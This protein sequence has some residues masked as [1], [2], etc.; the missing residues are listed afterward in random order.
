MEPAAEPAPDD[1]RRPWP[2]PAGP[3]TL[4]M[5]WHE[6]VFLHWPVPAEALRPLVPRSLELETREGSAWLGIVPFRMSGVHARGLPSLPWLSAFPE[7]NVRTYV[8]HGARPGV[9]FFSL[10][11]ANPAAVRIARGTF[12]LP[13]FDARMRS[14]RQGALLE[15]A[16]T[17]THRGAPAARFE[18]RYRPTAPPRSSAPGSLEAWL[19]DRYCLYALDGRGRLRCG[20]IEHRAWPLQPAEVELRENTMAA[21]LGLA[22]DPR[23][24]LAHYSEELEV[25][26]WRPEPAG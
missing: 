13:Y 26:A 20:E 16:S 15:Y 21:P 7:L 2:A 9:W 22:L 5:R 25:V 14:A 1:A 8:R 23:P 4:A 11:A 10:D 3:W 18:G 6:L 17:R 24:P 19:T 12:H